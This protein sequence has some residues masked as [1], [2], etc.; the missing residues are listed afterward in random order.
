MRRAL[1]RVLTHR[2]APESRPHVAR[3]IKYIDTERANVA[4]NLPK[5]RSFPTALSKVKSKID[6]LEL[7]LFIE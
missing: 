1:S 3:T 4:Q 2:N 7:A 6:L 5:D